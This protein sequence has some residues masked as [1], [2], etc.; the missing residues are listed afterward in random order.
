MEKRPLN[1]NFLLENPTTPTILSI[2]SLEV[3][4]LFPDPDPTIPDVL[5]AA[6]E[7]I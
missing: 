6:T 4:T 2:E 7:P 5:L 3:A 1:S